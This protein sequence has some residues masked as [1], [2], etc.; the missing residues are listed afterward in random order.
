MRRSLDCIFEVEEEKVV[1]A[2]RYF[3]LRE[4]SDWT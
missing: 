3:H 2:E 4:S 1:V